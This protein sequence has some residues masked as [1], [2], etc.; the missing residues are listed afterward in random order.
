MHTFANRFQP[1]AASVAF[2]DG[3]LVVKLA[4]GRELSVPLECFPRLERASARERE[5]WELIGGGLGIHWPL[6][7]EDIS[8]EN[9]LVPRT[10]RRRKASK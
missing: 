5:K 10:G 7:D 3:R 8:V 4:D 1:L 6:I 2:T 9:L